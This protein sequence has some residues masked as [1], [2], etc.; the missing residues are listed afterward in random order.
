MPLRQSEILSTTVI[1]VGL[2][3]RVHWTST[4]QVKMFQVYV[5]H[6]LSWVG[7]DQ[8][9][10]IPISSQSHDGRIWIDVGAI[11]P[12]ELYCD[13]S[14]TLASAPLIGNA[15]LAWSGGT[16]LDDS[17]NDDVAG[18]QVHELDD[19]TATPDFSTLRDI[20]PA[21]PGGRITDG[22]GLGG[23]GDGGY[24]RSASSY[25]WQ[26]SGFASGNRTFAVVPFDHSGQT[27]GTGT[28]VT[29]AVQAAPMPS[30]VNNQNAGLSLSYAGNVTRIATL[31]WS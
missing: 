8:Y 4:S 15:S 19:P 5:N 1:Q 3:L 6:R 23:F 12:Q 21:Y 9:C 20:L 30:V 18:F 17:G 11:D 25:R 28:R 7:C 22:Y 16:Y 31:K 2:D 24:G 14:S 27:R 26:A 29:F 13:F 10:S